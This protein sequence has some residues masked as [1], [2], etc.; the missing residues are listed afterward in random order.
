M[1]A[2]N[3]ADSLTNLAICTAMDANDDSLDP[4][5]RA[6]LAEHTTSAAPLNTSTDSRQSEHQLTN[7]AP[8]TSSIQQLLQMQPDDTA[9]DSDSCGDRADNEWRGGSEAMN[10]D[11]VNRAAGQIRRAQ[12]PPAL[13]DLK[14]H[15][16]EML[17]AASVAYDNLFSWAEKK[18]AAV[19]TYY[20]MTDCGCDVGTAVMQAKRQPRR[21]MRSG[22]ERIQMKSIEVERELKG[23][24]SHSMFNI[25]HIGKHINR[26]DI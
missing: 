4:K 13:T 20:G 6:Q 3:A 23:L 2:A 7:L 9:V 17:T 21:G 11:R 18:A 14:Q 26:S 25:K 12:P 15:N 16:T 24:S 8:P 10:S 5:R 19:R 22:S 1:A